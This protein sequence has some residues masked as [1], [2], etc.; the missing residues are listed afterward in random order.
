[1]K[2]GIIYFKKS[3][4]ESPSYY[5]A[6]HIE[7]IKKLVTRLVSQMSGEAE[8]D[9][10]LIPEYGIA[11]KGILYCLEYSTR[12]YIKINRGQK[13]YILDEYC[14]ELNRVLIYTNCGRI[15]EIDK[16]ELIYTEF[17]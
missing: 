10:F 3:T 15:V 8:E 16:E 5:M 6:R 11:G 9:T 17:D 4:P 14:D 13:A 12:S 2:T 7:N 1:M